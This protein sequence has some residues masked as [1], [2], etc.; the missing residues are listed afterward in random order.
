VIPAPYMAR[1]HWVGI[2]ELSALRQP[3]IKELIQ[4][5]Y[6]MVFQKLPKRLQAELN[7]QEKAPAPKKALD[8]SKKKKVP[9]VSGKKSRSG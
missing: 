9:K 4:N 8:I 1:N 2:V 5:S 7:N 6:Q 3:E